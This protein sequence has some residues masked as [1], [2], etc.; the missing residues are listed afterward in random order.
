H[1]RRA[2]QA[3]GPRGVPRLRLRSVS[4]SRPAHAR[5]PQRN[6]GP[7]PRGTEGR[8]SDP[9]AGS[10]RGESSESR[11]DAV[12]RRLSLAGAALALLLTAGALAL[13]PGR[14]G[15]IQSGEVPVFRVAKGRF[16]R[17]LVAEGTLKAVRATSI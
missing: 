7:G 3:R 12:K 17:T 8:R 14:S 16:R 13:V 9:P 2:S 4:G 10:L 5:S 11:G 6:L 15:E 1:G